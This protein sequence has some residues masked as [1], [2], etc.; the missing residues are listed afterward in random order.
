VGNGPGRVE[1]GGGKYG[2]L[3]SKQINPEIRKLIGFFSS[4][5]FDNA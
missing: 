4:G 3:K 1:G 2:A 5:R